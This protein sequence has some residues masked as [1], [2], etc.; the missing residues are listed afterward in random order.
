MDEEVKRL[1][2]E[3]EV[4]QRNVRPQQIISGEV[5]IKPPVGAVS[6]AIKGGLKAHAQGFCLGHV[7]VSI[8]FKSH[9]A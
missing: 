8:W 7:L 9:A 4:R 1:R 2:V 6:K 5:V 3:E